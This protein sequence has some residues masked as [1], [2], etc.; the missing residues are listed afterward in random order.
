VKES[1]EKGGWKSSKILSYNVFCLGTS[2]LD[3]FIESG[4]YQVY[5]MYFN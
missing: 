1:Y 2:I 3:S 4:S 5:F